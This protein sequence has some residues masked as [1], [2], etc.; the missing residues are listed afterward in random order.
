M[1]YKNTWLQQ[2]PVF[3][4]K[5]RPLSKTCPNVKYHEQDAKALH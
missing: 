4:R 5:A 3:T 2:S 1:S